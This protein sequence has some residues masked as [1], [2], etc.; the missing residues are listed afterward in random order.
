M[1]QNRSLVI[2][3]RGDTL[4]FE[5]FDLSAQAVALYSSAWMDLPSDNVDLTLTARGQRLAAAEPSLLQSLTEG[6]GLGVVRLEVTGNAYD[7]HVQTKALP[8]I[9]DT[10]G[11]LGTP[12]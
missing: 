3:S 6:L 7:A 10:L 12:R 8:L 5:T 2:V 1:T 9:E 11:I 4:S